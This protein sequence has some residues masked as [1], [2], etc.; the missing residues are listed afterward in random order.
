MNVGGHFHPPAALSLGGG[1]TTH[2]TGGWVGPRADM[3]EKISCLHRF[4]PQTFQAIVCHYINYTI[5][6]PLRLKELHHCCTSCLG[7]LC[8]MHINAWRSQLVCNPL[9]E[10]TGNVNGKKCHLNIRYYLLYI[11]D[12]FVH[13][14]TMQNLEV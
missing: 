14:P 12:G 13:F 7:A 10:G 4:E 1:H 9:G 3:E 8:D 11:G 6:V 2:C 5:P